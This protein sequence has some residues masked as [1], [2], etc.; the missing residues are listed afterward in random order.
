MAMAPHQEAHSARKNSKPIIHVHMPH[1]VGNLIIG[2]SRKRPITRIGY[3]TIPSRLYQTKGGT[4][5]PWR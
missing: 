3:I 1:A 4:S 5:L 2:V